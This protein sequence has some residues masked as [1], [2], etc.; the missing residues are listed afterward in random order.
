MNINTVIKY[1]KTALF[2]WFFVG[3]VLSQYGIIEGFILLSTLLVGI[4]LYKI[5]TYHFFA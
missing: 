2:V 5:L 1:P 3:V 4:I